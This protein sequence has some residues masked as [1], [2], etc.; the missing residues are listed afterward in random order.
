ML[1]ARSLALGCAGGACCSA[2]Y[3]RTARALGGGASPLPLSFLRK[4]HAGE[5]LPR[6]GASLPGERRTG[7]CGGERV[8]DKTCSWRGAAPALPVLLPCARWRAGRKNDACA[9]SRQRAAAAWFFKLLHL[10]S[11][12]AV[13][14]LPRACAPWRRARAGGDAAGSAWLPVPRE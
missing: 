9:F 2:A 11:P 1:P 4:F 10:L 8:T 3:D 7:D 6:E 12:P 14:Y 5:T 13:T